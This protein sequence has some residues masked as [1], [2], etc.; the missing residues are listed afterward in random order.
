MMQFGLGAVLAVGCADL[1]R[2]AWRASV[3]YAADPRNPYVYAQTVPDAVRMA[4]RI[5]SLAALHPDGDRM[6]VTV[7][8]PPHEQWPLPWY[9]RN[10]PNVGYWIEP[11]DPVAMN[12][13][14]I[15]AAAAH[16]EILDATLGD[17]YVSE[18]FGLRPEVLMTLYAERQLWDHFLARVR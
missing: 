3:T 6:Q 7:I 2:Q 9:L 4:T 11:G 16:A 17:R 12:A 14:V 5:R 8:A 18:F 15:V 1:A 10:M 13:P